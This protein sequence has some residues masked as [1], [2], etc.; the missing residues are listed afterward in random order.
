MTTTVQRDRLYST[1]LDSLFGLFRARYSDTVT[2]AVHVDLVVSRPLNSLFSAQTAHSAC[3]F[4][5]EYN[6]HANH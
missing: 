1:V 4:A 3:V 6:C 2:I 5:L